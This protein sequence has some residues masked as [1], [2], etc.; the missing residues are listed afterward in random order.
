MQAQQTELT[1]ERD[2]ALALA[3]EEEIRANKFFTDRESAL[4]ELAERDQ[5][6][7]DLENLVRS[8]RRRLVAN[9]RTAEAYSPPEE[10]APPPATFVEL[11]DWIDSE[12]PLI[13]FSGNRDKTLALDR[14]PEADTWVR[15][16]WEVLRAM[17]AYAEGKSSKRFAGDF[18]MWCEKPPVD[19]Y[20]IPSGKVVRDESET[21]RNKPKWR[22]ERE[23]PVSYDISASGQVFMGAHV[24]IG[25]SG[26]GRI[27]PRL[28]FHDET[29][30]T[31]KIYVGYLGA[32]LTNTRT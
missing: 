12:L 20:M 2:L 21:V 26:S 22:R 1:E 9:G 30:Q 32:H 8:L 25:A 11:L 31:G 13:E 3:E 19:S 17:Q 7:W 28:Y 10:Q 5:R 16:S 29:G 6:V 15:S 18:K 4:A 23:F 24:R 14:S 27:N